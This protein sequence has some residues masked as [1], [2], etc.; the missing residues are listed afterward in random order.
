MTPLSA[1]PIPY[2]LN[3]FVLIMF[4]LSVLVLIYC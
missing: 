4:Y 3:I 1:E 2:G